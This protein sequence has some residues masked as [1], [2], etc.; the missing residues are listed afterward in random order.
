MG[1]S[2]VSPLPRSDQMGSPPTAAA[3]FPHLLLSLLLD[4]DTGFVATRIT[5]DH[6][7]MQGIDPSW[8]IAPFFRNGPVQ[9]IL[10]TVNNF[11]G[12]RISTA[13]IEDGRN[14]SEIVL[15]SNTFHTP[16]ALQYF[17]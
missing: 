14:P 9:F 8:F 11:F 16:R 12:F 2:I 10:A 17:N 6:L 1:G 5:F 3:F 13:E 4:C 7:S 15:V